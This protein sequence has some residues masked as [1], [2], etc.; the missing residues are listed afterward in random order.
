MKRYLLCLVLYLSACA[1]GSFSSSTL[2]ASD[3]EGASDAGQIE[4]SSDVLDAETPTDIS[5]AA[6]PPLPDVEVDAPGGGEGG[7][8]DTNTEPASVFEVSAVSTVGERFICKM[9]NAERVDSPTANQTHTRFNLRATDL[10]A[11]AIVD[12]R[13][14]LFFGD[15][16]GYRDIWRIGE[17][18]DSV[19]HVSF[20]AA[21]ADL[22]VL[23]RDLAFY[24]T[25]DDPSVAHR[26][27]PAIQR[28]F[29]GGF[30]A[31]P[32]GEP[33][34]NYVTRR[35]LESE[36]GAF[37]GSFEVPSG[38]ITTDSGT[39]IF[40]SGRVREEVEW[41][42]S[43]G[44]VAR[45]NSAGASP[46]FYQILYAV[47]DLIDGR[48]L[49]GHFVQN[50]PVEH[51]GQLYLFGTGR[52]RKD[53]VHLARK[54]V[55]AIEQPGGFE[56]YNPQSNTWVDPTALSEP[57]RAALPAIID[58]SHRGI[59]ELG[60]QYVP[61]ADLFVMMFQQIKGS[62]AIHLLVSR[63]PTGPWQRTRVIDM[64]DPLFLS[65]HC[66]SDSG[67]CH[68]DAIWRCAEAGLYAPYP[69]PLIRAEQ[70]GEDTWRLSVPYV[71]STWTPYNV[72]LFEHTVDV[73]MTLQ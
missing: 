27:D 57:E 71:V 18:P 68:G 36:H 60:V 1:S 44:F 54:P 55:T 35:L 19:G 45:W 56:I 30:L 33:L 26:S 3:A 12:G 51:D 48:A 39:Y 47:D 21:K 53:G 59:G 69:L 73:S 29:E 2:D 7:P 70:R 17:D 38:A 37:A 6:S 8:G 46:L 72:V 16:H 20:E 14:H 24:V 11:P 31:P 42:M 66:C 43:R 22:S 61:E 52:Y 4:A 15:T 40:W 10:G 28:D 64:S 49:G 9:I 5:D 58:E 63:E 13:L 67:A 34:S 23:C 32:P 62:N 41:E 50:A 65:K 25:P